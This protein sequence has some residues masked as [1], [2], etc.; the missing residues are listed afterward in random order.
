MG[1]LAKEYTLVFGV[2]LFI[3]SGTLYLFKD[4]K[5][6]FTAIVVLLMISLQLD[7][8]IQ[9]EQQNEQRKHFFHDL[10]S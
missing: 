7:K 4:L 6:I 8:Q 10:L 2:I 1:V 9:D 5:Y 3:V